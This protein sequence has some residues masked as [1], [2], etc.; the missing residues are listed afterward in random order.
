MI[1]EE[2]YH[3]LASWSCIVNLPNADLSTV[4]PDP[5]LRQHP[6]YSVHVRIEIHQD[7]SPDLQLETTDLSRGGCY[8]QLAVPLSVGIRLH[9]TLWLAECPVAIR[10]LIVTRHPEFGNGI[11]FVGFEGEGETLL[12]QY[13]AAITA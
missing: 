1:M 11:M 9:A 13:L 4:I 5:D 8:I 12:G 10:G 7:A 3:N 2:P 6:R